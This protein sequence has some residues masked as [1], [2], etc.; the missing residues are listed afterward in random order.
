MRLLAKQKE[1]RFPDA[2]TVRMALE[3]YREPSAAAATST[4][5]QDDPLTDVVTTGGPDLS[6][7]VGRQ[8]PLPDALR[9]RP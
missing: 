8:P 5:R 9:P 1:Q 6:G 3:R 2:R 7:L 4:A